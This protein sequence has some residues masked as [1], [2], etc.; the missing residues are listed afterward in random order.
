MGPASSSLRLAL[1]GAQGTGKT[2]LLGGLAQRLPGLAVIPEQASVII[3]E[4]RI[5]RRIV[6]LLRD[7]HVPYL[8]IGSAD[9]QGRVD[10]V[11]AAVAPVSAS[12]GR[13]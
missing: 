8:A 3:R 4:R 11:L 12:Q 13:A 6:E 1:C 9:R 10:E 5:E 7:L 2:T